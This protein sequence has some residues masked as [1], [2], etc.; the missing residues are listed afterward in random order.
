MIGNCKKER[1]YSPMEII[2]VNIGKPNSLYYNGKEL[3]TGIYKSPVNIPLYVTASNLE[4][5]G[6]ADLEVHGGVNKALCIY[7]EEHYPYWGSNLNKKLEYGAF[8]ENLTIRGMLETEVFIGDIYQL[9]E[10]IVQVSQPRQ[11]CYKLAMK[12][13]VPDLPVKVIDTGYSGYYFRVLKEGLFPERR[14]IELVSKHPAGISIAYANKI[15]FHDRFNIEGIKRILAVEE[16][17]ASWRETFKLR[18]KDLEK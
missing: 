11:P 9:G 1:R 12:H 13:D 16:L 8:G 7:C 4:G 15:R 10:A 14:S 18:L 5:D 2:S 17:S 6:Q 3:F